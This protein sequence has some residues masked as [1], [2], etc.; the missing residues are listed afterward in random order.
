MVGIGTPGLRVRR[1]IATGRDLLAPLHGITTVTPPDGGDWLT[2]EQIRE[3]DSSRMRGITRAIPKEP[4]TRSGLRGTLSATGWEPPERM[5]IDE[6]ATYGEII[7]IYERGSRWAAGDWLLE[8]E[9]RWGEMYS[10]HMEISGLAYQTLVNLASLCRHVPR[11]NRRPELGI[12]HHKVIARLPPGEQ[13]RWLGAAA[14]EDWTVGQLSAAVKGIVTLQGSDISTLEGSNSMEAQGAGVSMSGEAH[15]TVLG[16]VS[17]A[18]R[19]LTPSGAYE[20]C[21]VALEGV[22]QADWPTALREMPGNWE[23]AF[24][25]DLL[26]RVVAAIMDNLA[27]LTERWPRA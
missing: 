2:P 10:Q 19:W 21:V 8:G 22:I 16:T 27:A 1:E 17:A 25:A 9:R 18:E 24:L 20:A 12:A 26:D 14:D 5:T 6:W 7:G 3:L 15:V 23:A 13:R 11:E 4:Q